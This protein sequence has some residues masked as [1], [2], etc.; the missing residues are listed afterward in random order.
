MPED[1]AAIKL[2]INTLSCSAGGTCVLCYCDTYLYL[3]LLRVVFIIRPV[4]HL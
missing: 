3:M 4:N 2:Q 1:A